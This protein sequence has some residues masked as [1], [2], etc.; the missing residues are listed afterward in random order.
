M[1]QNGNP[2]P[3]QAAWNARMDL[4]VLDGRGVIRYKHVFRP[5]VF[6]K[7]VTTLLKEQ[8]SELRRIKEKK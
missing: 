5:E 4:Y 3:I 8:E 7:A 6:V 2:G 1:A